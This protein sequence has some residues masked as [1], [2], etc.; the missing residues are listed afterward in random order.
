M[1]RQQRKVMSRML[2]ALLALLVV[3]A[4][5]KKE[6]VRDYKFDEAFAPYISAY[7]SETVPRKSTIQVQL[8][9]DVATDDMIGVQLAESPFEFKPAIEGKARWTGRRS[10]E[11]EPAEPMPS[12]QYYQAALPLKGFFEGLSEAQETFR[13]NF[14]TIKQTFSVIQLGTETIDK[15]TLKWQAVNGVLNTA[16]FEFPENV[17]KLLHAEHNG[18]DLKVKWTHSLH[19]LGHNYRID[20][21]PRATDPGVVKLTWDGSPLGIEAEG[22]EEVA[23]LALGDFNATKAETFN[24]P[25]QYV[26]IQFSDP[27]RKNQNLDGLIRMEDYE[28]RFVISGNEV[29]AYPRTRVVG[30]VALTVEPGVR[31]VLGHKLQDQTTFDIQFEEPKPEV[32]LVGNGTIMPR[33]GS[34]LPFA[35]ESVNLSAVEIRVMRIYEDNILQ[36]L[37]VNNLDGSTQLR[38]VGKEVHKSVIRLDGNPKANMRTWRRSTV[39]LAKLIDMEPGAIYRVTID[40]LQEHSLY[41]CEDGEEGEAA[42]EE[43]DP[44]EYGYYRSSYYERYNNRDNPCHEAYFNYQSRAVSR[45]VLASELGLIAK[46][47]SDGS[48]TLAVNDCTPRSPS[49]ASNSNCTT[50]SSS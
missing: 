23:I 20:S 37:Q 39:D 35:F 13:F 31:N 9:Q 4:C 19:G 21:V 40:F 44:D 36:F 8:T 11:F 22:S 41:T 10:L 34:S 29:K 33:Q 2:Y 32:R 28:L 30:M 48:L 17:E 6:E 25:E 38:L 5:G 14:E 50:S 49:A 26:S 1:A 45:N 18:K 12:G 47:G 7:T 3:S 15:Q 24:D 46:S 42:E 16:D 27:L 43:E